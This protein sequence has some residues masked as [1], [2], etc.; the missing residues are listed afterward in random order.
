[1]SSAAVLAVAGLSRRF[2][3]V[4]AVDDVSF[5]VPRGEFHAVIGANGAGKTTLFNL[6]TGT[7]RPSAGAVR[8]EGR[9]ITALAPH[10]RARLGIGRTFQIN[11]VFLSKTV[12]ANI[13]IAIAARE[14]GIWNFF[15]DASAQHRAE[16]EQIAQATGL[17]ECIDQPA[18]TLSYG[19]RRRLE[20]AIAL[21]GRPA[22]LLLDEPTCGMS[23]ADRPALVALI[24]S[25]VSARGMTAVLVEHD[26]DVVFAVA[27][28]ITVMHRGRL[29]AQGTPAEIA[30]HAEVRS[31]YLGGAH[32]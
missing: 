8:F 27:Q 24:R 4:K 14:H 26:M 19:D 29:L 16:T 25:L 3:G 15:A 6:V 1:M 5:E 9:D 28:R 22:L 23:S 2:G 11:N 32:G 12:A 31:I 7:L 30:A 18:A 17:A 13:R 20:L 21:A 10:R